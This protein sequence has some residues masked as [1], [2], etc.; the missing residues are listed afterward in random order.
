MILC[1]DKKKRERAN[2]SKRNSAKPNFLSRLQYS[3]A[4]AIY[5]ILHFIGKDFAIGVGANI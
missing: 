1:I 2:L 4:R 3:G 5:I